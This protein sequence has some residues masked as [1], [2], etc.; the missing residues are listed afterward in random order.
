MGWMIL[1]FVPHGNQV[2]K[3]SKPSN[4]ASSNI[5]CS[6]Y[7]NRNGIPDNDDD[8]DEVDAVLLEAG[9]SVTKQQVKVRISVV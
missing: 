6:R 9:E 5:L 4:W 2:I 8:G 7:G 3:L 1:N